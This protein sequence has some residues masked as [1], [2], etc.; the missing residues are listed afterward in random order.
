MW[1][2]KLREGAKGFIWW[3]KVGLWWFVLRWLK[4]GKPLTSLFPFV[5]AAIGDEVDHSFIE[6]GGVESSSEVDMAPKPK[7]LATALA[8]KKSKAVAAPTIQDPPPGSVGTLSPTEALKLWNPEFAATE[9]ERIQKVMANRDCIF[10]YSSELKKVQRK[11]NS[12]A[13]DRK[14]A[15]EKLATA[16]KY[17][18]TS[19][20]VVARFLIE[21]DAALDK[22]NEALHGLTKLQKVATSP[23]YQMIFDRGYNRA[24]DYYTR[25]VAELCPIVL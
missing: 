25:Q 17:R 4:L 1:L 16:K 3:S 24:R 6:G 13:T 5:L 9:L 8:T 7:N 21:V 15:T 20:N 22:M 19:D 11:A 18:A 2:L 12:L 14:T 23:V 10:K